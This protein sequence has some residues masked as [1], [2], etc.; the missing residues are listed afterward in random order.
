[1]MKETLKK[2]LAAYGATGREDRVCEVI[3]EMVAPFVDTVEKDAMG[4]LICT[5][6]GEGA[7]VMLA[8]HMDQIGFM[9]MDIDEKGFLRVHNVGGIRRNFSLNRHVVF[10]NGVHGVVS[11][12]IEGFKAGETSV[13][14]L[15][16]DI[17]MKDR[18]EA[19]AK[20][21]IGDVAVY[22]P[23]VFELGED[24]LA[25]PSMDNR[26][27]CAVVVEAL[28]LLKDCPNEVVAVFTVQEEVGLRGARAAAY[29]VNP[30]IGIALDVTIAGDTPKGYKFPMAVGKGPC[31]KILDSSVICSPKVVALMEDAAERAGI[32]TQREV[33]TAGGT[34]AGAMQQV[35]GGVPCGVISIACRYVHSACET[36]SVSDAVACAKL[37]A[38]M[39][40]NK[41]EL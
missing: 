40:N 22:V 12:E 30:D 19:E 15:F 9:V 11:H 28:K 8:A 4:N 38:E 37:L 20:V 18:A 24:L 31:V 13:G 23:D 5:K 17:G 29:S 10:A 32:E 39:L 41:I 14:Q 1:M 21:S 3:R 33:L 25:S 2:L 34:D 7:R 36:I 6:K 26:V 27:G 16:I 35:R